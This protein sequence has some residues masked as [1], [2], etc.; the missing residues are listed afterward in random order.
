MPVSV[1]ED[2]NPNGPP[3][4]LRCYRE[5]V[6]RPAPGFSHLVIVQDDVILCLDFDIALKRLLEHVPDRLVALF[7]AGAPRRSAMEIR[8]AEKRGDALCDMSRMDWVP[9]VALVWPM[10]LAEEFGKYLRRVPDSAWADD[11][12]VGGWCNRKRIRPLATVPSLVQHPDVEPSLLPNDK[13]AG[14][15]NGYRT[16]AVWRP[17][18]SPVRD[19]W[20]G[21]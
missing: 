12:I 14:G 19:G 18:W 11:P 8:L 3:S 4:P 1:I 21:S 10:A 2:P 7:V 20:L 5:C 6:T 17:G 16:A 9:T 15:K 13:S